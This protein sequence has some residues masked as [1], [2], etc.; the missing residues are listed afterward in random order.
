MAPFRST[1]LRTALHAEVKEI[2]D[3]CNCCASVVKAQ[4]EHPPVSHRGGEDHHAAGDARQ[5]QHF[6]TQGRK[7]HPALATVS[8]TGAGLLDRKGLCCPHTLLC[9]AL[10]RDLGARLLPQ[11]ENGGEYILE[12]ID[13]LQKNSW[14]ADIQDCIDP[15]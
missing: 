1:L 6:R 9:A 14:V 10:A 7:P 4:S 13:S 15:G 2:E 12:T 8:W 5:G 11:V 3:C